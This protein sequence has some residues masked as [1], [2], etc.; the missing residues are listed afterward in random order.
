MPVPAPKSKSKE[1]SRQAD[2][3]EEVLTPMKSLHLAGAGDEPGEA[4]VEVVAEHR[5]NE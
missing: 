1:V 2:E 3:V 4:G 5:A